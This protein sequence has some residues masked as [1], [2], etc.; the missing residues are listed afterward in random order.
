MIIYSKTLPYGH[1]V[2]TATLFGRLEKTA[3]HI[4]VKKPSLIRPIL[5][6]PLVRV[7]TAFHSNSNNNND[8]QGRESMAC[9]NEIKP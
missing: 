4:L 7:L 9:K 3:L 1:L 5:F 8:W 6:G 2:I